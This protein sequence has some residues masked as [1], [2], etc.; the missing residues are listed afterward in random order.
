L[1]TFDV[2]GMKIGVA[3]CYDVR[4]PEL[5]LLL[6]GQGRSYGAVFQRAEPGANACFILTVLYRLVS[7]RRGSA[8]MYPGSLQHD[9]WTSA[10][11]TSYAR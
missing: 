10:L 4:F 6:S 7:V 3:I 5:S 2:G 8:V 1:T 9:Y 11:G